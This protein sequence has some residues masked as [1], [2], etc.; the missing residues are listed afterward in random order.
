MAQAGQVTESGPLVNGPKYRQIYDHLLEQFQTGMYS[1]SDPMP[2]ERSLAAT[3]NVAVG[4]MRQALRKLESDGFIRRIPGKGTFV[5]S[6]RQQREQVKTNVFAVIVPS[7]AEDPYS[8]LVEGVERAAKSEYRISVGSSKH[9]P[10]IQEQLIHQA[11]KDNVAG[12]AIVPTATPTPPE[13]IR[14]IQDSHIPVVLCHRAVPGVKA[15]LVNLSFEQ[16]GRMTAETLLQHGHRRITSLVAMRYEAVLSVGNGIRGAMQ[17]HGIDKS[18]YRIHY[19][20]VMS[21]DHR[22]SFINLH[23]DAIREALEQI[24]N[25]KNRPTAIHCGNSLDAETVY[26]E[27]I[28]LGFNIPEDLS[29]IYFGGNRPRGAISTRLTC[30]A[31]DERELG[32]WAGRLLSEMSSGLRRHDNQEVIEVPLELL[33]GE[34]VGPPA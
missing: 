16:V 10:A 32:V 15:P 30:V 26:L 18:N 7:I 4:T 11:I 31:R 8:S 25:D 6:P 33:P 28:N 14:L 2:G 22:Q 13:Q 23:R 19:H 5:N 12:V 17:E 27:A 20:G 21:N 24:L 1:P 9:D 29:L 34:T 3:M